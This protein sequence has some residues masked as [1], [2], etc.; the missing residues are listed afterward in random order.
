MWKAI[1]L[2]L[3]INVVL[4]V[5]LAV[6]TKGYNDADKPENKEKWLNVIEFLT[7]AKQNGLPL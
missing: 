5:L 3:A 4:D 2:K 7:K 6:A 1:L